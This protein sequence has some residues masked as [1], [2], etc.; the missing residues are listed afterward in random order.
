[1]PGARAH[2]DQ[3][4]DIVVVQLHDPVVRTG[5]CPLEQRVEGVGQPF[6]FHRIH[7]QQIERVHQ[8]GEMVDGR[9]DDDE[10]TVRSE[11]ARELRS[12]PGREDIGQHTD[13]RVV[14]RQRPPDIGHDRVGSGVGARGSPSG[15]LRR[16]DREPVRRRHAVEDAGE[17]MPGAGAGVQHETSAPGGR[18]NVTYR[19]SDGGEVTG[20]EKPGAGRDHRGAVAGMG[21][22][23]GSELDVPLAGGIEAVPG[24]AAHRGVGRGLGELAPTDRAAQVP[25]YLAVQDVP[26]PRVSRPR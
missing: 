9:G 7:P 3:R 18:G 10:H 11:D 6:R 1:V 20:G 24:R 12:V 4:A 23:S 19:R 5:R 8:F 13:R 16:V 21:Q 22:G 14:D 17:M 25:N 26:P 2:G 15:G